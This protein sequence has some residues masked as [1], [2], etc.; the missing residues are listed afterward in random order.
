MALSKTEFKALVSLLED[1]DKDIYQQIESKLIATGTE[2]IP[3]LEKSWEKSFDPL[4]QSR[5]ERVIHKIQFD[6]V[7]SDLLIWKLSNQSNLLDAL[8]IINRYQYPSL[9]EQSVHNILADLR[10]DCWFYLMYEMSPVEKV[11]LLNNVIFRDYGLS[12]NTTEY[13]APQNSYIQKVLETKKGNPITLACIYSIVAQKLDIPIYGV[14][15]PRHF[16]LAYMENKNTEAL[17]YINVFNRGQIMR[18]EDIHSFLTQLNLPKRDEFI[19]PCDNLTIVKRVLRNL[20]SSYEK[21]EKKDKEEE[22]KTL[23]KLIGE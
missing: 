18:L 4:Q 19:L 15:L 14:N 11:R 17:F 1:P 21:L 9:D 2:A 16:I 23:L 3:F 10:R 12:G 7:K 5:I 22:I 6:Q 8:L 20:V 13:H